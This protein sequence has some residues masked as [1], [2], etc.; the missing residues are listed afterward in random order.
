[1]AVAHGSRKPGY[2]NQRVKECPGLKHPAAGQAGTPNVPTPPK[3]QPLLGQIYG[4]TLFLG[5]AS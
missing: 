4:L 5:D 2:W 3:C 1:V